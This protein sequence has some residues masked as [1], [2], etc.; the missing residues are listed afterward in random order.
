[1]IAKKLGK[2][3]RDATAEDIRTIVAEINRSTKYSYWTAVVAYLTCC[4][5]ALEHGLFVGVNIQNIDGT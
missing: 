5:W 2:N 3:F 4:A 1:V